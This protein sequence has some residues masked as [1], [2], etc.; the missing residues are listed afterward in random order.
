MIDATAP[1]TQRSRGTLWIS[2]VLLSIPAIYFAGR[3]P[4]LGNADRLADLGKLAGYGVPELVLYLAGLAALTVGYVLA[5]RT[6]RGRRFREV[7]LP[8]LAISAVLLIAFATLYPVN[9]IDLFIYAV[10]SHLLTSYGSN[11]NAVE[12][13]WFWEYDPYVRFASREWADNVSPY[14][15][16]WN[17]IASPATLFDGDRILVALLIFK[18]LVI[19][20]ALIVAWFIHDIVGHDRPGDA[21]AATV[22]WLWNPLLLWEGIGNGHNDVIVMLPVLVA[23]WCWRRA[24]DRWVLPLLVASVLIKYVTALLLPFALVMLWHR[25]PTWRERLRLAALSVGS[26]LLIVYLTLYPYFDLDALRESFAAQ[27]GLFLTSPGAAIVSIGNRLDWTIDVAFWTRRVGDIVLGLITLVLVALAWR[28]RLRLE[29]A[30]FEVMFAFLL[31]ASW[32]FRPWYLIWLVALVALVP[33]GWPQRRVTVWTV[34]ALLSYA[35]YIWIREWWP[36]DRFSFSLTGIAITFVPVVIVTGTELLTGPWRT[37]ASP[38]PG[39]DAPPLSGGTRVEVGGE[40]RNADG[41]CLNSHRDRLCGPPRCGAAH[42]LCRRGRWCRSGARS[43][44][45]RSPAPSARSAPPAARSCP[46]G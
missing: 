13:Q 16:L 42:R 34:S 4:L 19:V 9:A 32:N 20:S 2:G 35:H 6:L 17:L 18:A 22:A 30:L 28:R 5:I 29:R 12:P 8:V 11:P 31:V 41:A 3:Y 37:A 44:G 1:R 45:V 40:D 23:I 26:S 7:R 39:A 15:P 27:R 24:H 14:G 43:P 33:L 25:H 46:G 21:A 38:H 10:R 36:W